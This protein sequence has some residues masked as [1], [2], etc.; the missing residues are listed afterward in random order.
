MKIWLCILKPP[1]ITDKSYT[2]F[3]GT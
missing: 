2:I 3:S 1:T